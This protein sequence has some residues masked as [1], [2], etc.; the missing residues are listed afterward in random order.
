MELENVVYTLQKSGP[1]VII[2]DFN[3]HISLPDSNRDQCETNPQGR[4]LLRDLSTALGTMP[5]HCVTWPQVLHIPSMAVVVGTR[6]LT[7]A[8]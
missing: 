8:F 7:S 3:A 1:V 4:D 2:G 5:S 6:Q